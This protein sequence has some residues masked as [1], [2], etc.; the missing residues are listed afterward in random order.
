MYMHILCVI[1]VGKTQTVL[2]PGPYGSN[3]VACVVSVD[4]LSV[5]RCSFQG[6]Q[7]LDLNPGYFIVI[8][9]NIYLMRYNYYNRHIL[10]PPLSPGMPASP[11][12]HPLLIVFT[13]INIHI[14]QIISVQL[15]NVVFSF[16]PYTTS[17]WW[18]LSVIPIWYLVNWAKG[19]WSPPKMSKLYNVHFTKTRSEYSKPSLIIISHI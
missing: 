10:A 6:E 7:Y 18:D 3:Y 16:H 4:A 12:A 15:L 9:G 11:E 2:K 17:I 8:P 1:Y 13:N 14:S 5:C 19:P